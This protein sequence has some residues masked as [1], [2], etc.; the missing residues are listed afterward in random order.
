VSPE[1]PPGVEGYFLALQEKLQA[2]LEVSG[3]IGHPTAT[4]D[5]SE[6]NWLGMLEGHLPARYKPVPKCFVVDHTGQRSKEID[7][8]LCDRQY[9]TMVFRSESRFFVPAESLYAVFEVKQTLNKANVENACE[10]TKSVR[11]LERTN[12]SIVHAGGVIEKPKE[13]S[14]I[15]SGLLTTS[16][17][18]VDGPGASFVRTLSKQ[19]PIARL[20][21]GCVL[22]RCGWTVEPETLQVEQSVPEH[23]LIHFYL[24]LLEQLQKVGTVPGMEL[25]R[26]ASFLRVR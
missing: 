26:W 17:E 15:I 25:A 10:K 22:N 23:S 14:R 7:L 12:A 24:R 2:S 4:G 18:W 21:V 6:V 5:E 16:T 1:G 3:V 19:D 11:V 8:A 9:S 13:P 20:D